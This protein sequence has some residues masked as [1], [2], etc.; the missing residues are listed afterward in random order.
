MPSKAPKGES[1]RMLLKGGI[2]SAAICK[3]MPT[4]KAANNH[5]FPPMPFLINGEDK[6]L[7]ESTRARVIIPK[8]AKANVRASSA[9]PE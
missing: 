9:F 7:I 2:V 5:G 4:P 1:V 6:S 8:S 3:I